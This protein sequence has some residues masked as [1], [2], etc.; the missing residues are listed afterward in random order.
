MREPGPEED[1]P[2][3]RRRSLPTHRL[4][5]VRG[6]PP[7]G[8]T[9]GSADATPSVRRRPTYRLALH[10]KAGKPLIADGAAR[11]DRRLA[12]RLTNPL[13]R[14]YCL[15]DTGGAVEVAD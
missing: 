2:A 13:R 6:S 3:I 7:R 8:R 12:R 11:C 10:E 14:G 4:P 5:D 9:H 1:N 15:Q